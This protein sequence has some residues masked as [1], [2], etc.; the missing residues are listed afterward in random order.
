MEA[1]GFLRNTSRLHAL[2]YIYT[3]IIR[4]CLIAVCRSAMARGG[5]CWSP[6]ALLLVLCG[7]CWSAGPGFRTALTSKGLDYS[8]H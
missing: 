3:I 7:S 8:K 2:L 1:C 4:L 6:L 5:I